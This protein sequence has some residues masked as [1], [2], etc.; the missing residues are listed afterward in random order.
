[1]KRIILLI[2]LTAV[3]VNSGTVYKTLPEPSCIDTTFTERNGWIVREICDRCM[4]L[5]SYPSLIACEVDS[6]YLITVGTLSCADSMKPPAII[7]KGR[8]VARWGGYF[9]DSLYLTFTPAPLRMKIDTIKVDTV[10][11]VR[12]CGMT[13]VSWLTFIGDDGIWVGACDSVWSPILNYTI[14]T[15]YYLTPEQVKMLE[16]E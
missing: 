6:I 8:W 10:S 13:S 16:G 2:I 1:M 9:N 15:T 3:T 14:D 5:P 7:D 4:R 12:E 11:W